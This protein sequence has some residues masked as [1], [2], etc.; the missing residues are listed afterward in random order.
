MQ[1][2][3]AYDFVIK[4]LETGLPSF[5]FLPQYANT[6]KNVIAATEYIAQKEIFP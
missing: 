1:Y 5:I 3:Q 2:Q 4:K 6:I